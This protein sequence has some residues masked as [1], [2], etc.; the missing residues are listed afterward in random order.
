[1]RWMLVMLAACGTSKPQV[2]PDSG[3]PLGDGGATTIDVPAN[4]WTWVPIAGTTCANGSPAGIGVNRAPTAGGKLNIYFE[5]GGACWDTASCTAN[6]PLAVNLDVTYD[7]AKL[8]SDTAGLVVDRSAGEPVAS[9]TYVFVPY[10]TGDLHAGTQVMAYPGGP[11]IHHTGG[12]NTQKFV[13]AL[14]AAFPDAPTLWISG[15]SAGGYG[16]TLNFHR[17]TQAWPSA[18]ADLLEDSSP[19]I[20]FLANYDKL[21]SAWAIAFPPG[22]TGCATSFTSVFDAVATAHPTSRIGLMTFDDDATI[23]AYF[24]YASSLAP[25]QDDL[26]VHHFDH[27]NTKV[28]EATGTSHTMLGSVG[29]ISSHGVQLATWITQWLVGDP[30][31]ATVRP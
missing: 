14:H 28:F 5:G 15:S 23:K 17:F 24:G 19:F 3:M 10:C 9:T 21:T 25:V 31:W 12:T 11:T 1:M 29:S 8:A 7:A 26:I 13:D 30:A 2:A 27:P 16:A 22:C 6:P 18:Q 20:P 4:V